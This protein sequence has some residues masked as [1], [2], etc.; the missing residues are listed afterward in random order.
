[1]RRHNDQPEILA[2]QL[3]PTSVSIIANAR[4]MVLCPD[5]GCCAWVY[6]QRGVLKPHHVRHVVRCEDSRQRTRKIRCSGSGQRIRI[7]LTREEHLAFLYKVHH[8]ADDR[9][10]ARVHL[11]PT[12]PVPPP[13]CRLGQATP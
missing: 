10:A 11:V 3:P 2:S 5:P 6:V 1:V 7:D 4:T 12:P 9:R 8:A 13:V